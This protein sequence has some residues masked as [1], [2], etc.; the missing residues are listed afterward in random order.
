MAK[1]PDLNRLSVSER[2][3]NLAS[4]AFYGPEM[5]QGGETRSP[6]GELVP[7]AGYD[8]SQSGLTDP[9]LANWDPARGRGIVNPT[10]EQ[11]TIG[12]SEAIAKGI[13]ETRGLLPVQLAVGQARMAKQAIG[14]LVR[15]A[16]AAQRR[17]R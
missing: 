1:I 6:E 7:P 5:G 16:K 4:K 11:R 9:F 17:F 12:L 14:S 2:V 3:F 10:Y 13:G 8:P 15:G